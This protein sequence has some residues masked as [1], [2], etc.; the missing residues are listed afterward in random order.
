MVP[1]SV[2]TSVL[3]LPDGKRLTVSEVHVSS[4]LSLAVSVSLSISGV[5]RRDSDRTCH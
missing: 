4:E 3:V 2:V 5:T 1:G